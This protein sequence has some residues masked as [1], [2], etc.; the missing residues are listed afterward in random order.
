MDRILASKVK[1]GSAAFVAVN[2]FSIPNPLAHQ[3]NLEQTWTVEAL[4]KVSST[5]STSS[6][7]VRN[8]NAGLKINNGTRTL[9]YLNAGEHDYYMY[10]TKDLR[11]DQWHHLAFVFH[12]QTGLRN[13]YVDGVLDNSTGPNR[14][15][16]P[17][18]IAQTLL[19]GDSAD[20][21][22]DELRFWDYNRTPEQI[23]QFKDKS[24]SPQ[25]GLR[26]YYKMDGNAL[27]SS[28]NGFHG[29]VTSGVTW[30]DEVIP[31][32][33]KKKV[34][35]NRIKHGSGIFNGVNSWVDCGV[36]TDGF[37]QITLESWFKTEG[38][39]NSTK[40][41]IS[42]FSHS[43]VCQGLAIS[44]PAANQLAIWYGDGVTAYNG[45]VNVKAFGV[46]L[47]PLGEWNHVA[48]TYDGSTIRVY[49]NTKLV[50]SITTPVAFTSY[51]TVLGRWAIS[52]GDY[53]YS[54]SI[55][56]ARVWNYARSE[57]Q[58][59]ALYDKV[60]LKK[61]KGLVGYY[62]MRGNTMDSSGNNNHATAHN[63]A[64]SEDKNLNVSQVI[65]FD[66][67]NTVDYA[68]ITLPTTGYTMECWI[69]PN[70]IPSSA[71]FMNKFGN[72]L[73][74]NGD[75]SFFTSLIQSDTTQHT[76]YSRAGL[77]KVGFWNHVAAT[78]DGTTLRIY[79][80][81]LLVASKAVTG[82]VFQYSTQL[83]FGAYGDS[84]RS[85]KYYGKLSA[86]KVWNRAL[87]PQ[88]L[89]SSMFETYPANQAN[90][91]DQILFDGNTSS[92]KGNTATPYG[93]LV[94]MSD[95]PSMKL[96]HSS[97]LQH[98][99]LVTSKSREKKVL[100]F[101][102][103]TSNINMGGDVGAVG[104]K[105]F[106]IGVWMKSTHTAAGSRSVISKAWYGAIEHRY[107]L[108]IDGG[109]AKAFICTTSA[110]GDKL[111]ITTTTVCDGNWHF[112]VASYDRD[113]LAKIYVDGLFEASVDISNGANVDMTYPHPF[114]IGAYNSQTNTP[115]LFFDGE[116][117]DPF[118]YTRLLSDEEIKSIFLTH[119]LPN[120][121]EL[122]EHWNKPTTEELSGVNGIAG[123][124][125]NVAVM[126]STAPVEQRSSLKFTRSTG[127]V[128]IP[129]NA[130]LEV[131]TTTIM[132]WFRLPTYVDTH[133]D[134]VLELGNN[135]SGHTF[136][137]G[138]SGFSTSIGTHAGAGRIFYYNSFSTGG[139]VGTT[140]RVDDNIW[141]HMAITY[142]HGSRERKMYL[143]GELQMGKTSTG[144]LAVAGKQWT[145]G[146]R[147]TGTY[148]ISGELSNVVILNNVLTADE[149]KGSMHKY[150]PANAPNLVEQFKLSE[151]AGKVAYGTKGN[152][153]VISGN[154]AWTPASN[155]NFRGKHLYF[156]GTTSKALQVTLPHIKTWTF[157]CWVYKV[158]GY[159]TASS[160]LHFL[161][162]NISQNNFTIKMRGT[163]Y[164]WKSSESGTKMSTTGIASDVWKHLAVT[165]DG[166][167]LMFY[168]DGV[169]AG[170][171]A[172]NNATIPAGDYLIG[173]TGEY[174]QCKLDD[175]RLWDRVLTQTEIQTGMPLTFNRENNLILNHGFESNFY[176]ASGSGFH[177]TPISDPVIAET[178]NEKLL[179]LPLIN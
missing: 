5:A 88:E 44:Q 154:A 89:R 9:L 59:A 140:K 168:I 166:T 163:P 76:I 39:T 60:I 131:T 159:E 108:L 73:A 34:Q 45:N 69:N 137:I 161:T 84:S 117:V 100:K 20:V 62:R 169:A 157:E 164:Y 6:F 119:K 136:Q 43:P 132:F 109:K 37:N 99:D 49:L 35:S 176:D 25:D 170:T 31:A 12:N 40:N 167:N 27:D 66:G 111:A 110:L 105:D 55:G 106:T 151:G 36:L 149:I 22:I 33:P 96:D 23:N 115:M 124:L 129:A 142:D 160:Y 91:L 104:L 138:T 63:V 1:Q 83:R 15:N 50:Y 147:L 134:V 64:W 47:L 139:S 125:E 155:M 133:N 79:V 165:Y 57:Q 81:G 41:I 171:H 16:T 86:G 141:H 51:K 14:T 178:D 11:D 7:L 101:N 150:F 98:L 179:L 58:L 56:E 116:L 122:V 127:I 70:S 87:T 93:T 114:R 172:V 94:F 174:T 2:S 77:I 75:G 92:T 144:T 82:T 128:T 123:M 65:E 10:G 30:S 135:N 156:D 121:V 107:A 38:L 32:L 173:G 103:T 17:S 95:V 48:A 118:M 26:A 29:T 97:K 46:T 158:G 4:V 8:M 80:N 68:N 102:G 61:Q 120:Q 90:M 175:I 24:V 71:I 148:G 54:G 146:G 126:P 18:G 52:Y 162:N 74:I 78:Y 42:C 177:G 112:V 28:G 152:N 19:I 3:A 153:G 85:Y 72:Y 113:G 13:V 145:F 143:D 67:S 21:I 130:A 53:W